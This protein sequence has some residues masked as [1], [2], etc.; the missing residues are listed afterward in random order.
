VFLPPFA[1]YQADRLAPEDFEVA[2]AEYRERLRRLFTDA[3]I[4]FRSQ[5]GGHY[6]E[7]QVLKPPFGIG[8]NGFGL[9]VIQP[10]EVPDERPRP[11]K[12]SIR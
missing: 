12:L 5:N 1:I 3:P 4:P 11:A 9:H 7:A 6:D 10:N 2:A 8:A